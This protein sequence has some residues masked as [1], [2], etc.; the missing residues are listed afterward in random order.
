MKN[1]E[2]TILIRVFLLYFIKFKLCSKLI[3]FLWK[4]SIASNNI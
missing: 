3:T 4:I 1:N 2:Y